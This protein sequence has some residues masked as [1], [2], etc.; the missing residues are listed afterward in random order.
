MIPHPLG[1]LA[2]ALALTLAATAGQAEDR[3][4]L[5][6]CLALLERTGQQSAG[7]GTPASRDAEIEGCRQLVWEWARRDARMSVDEKGQPLPPK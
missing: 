6:A 7:A 5:L 4:K 3:S 1:A 2:A